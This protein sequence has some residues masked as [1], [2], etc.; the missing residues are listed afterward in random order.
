[1]PFK[2]STSKDSPSIFVDDDYDDSAKEEKFLESLRHIDFFTPVGGLGSDRSR[3]SDPKDGNGSERA[4]KKARQ[5]IQSSKEKA[6]T[7]WQVFEAVYGADLELDG[8]A[9]IVHFEDEATT[10]S[11]LMAK[12]EKALQMSSPQATKGFYERHLDMLLENRKF[13][14]V[15]RYLERV[16]KQFTNRIADD[17]GEMRHYEGGFGR[18]QI[19][20]LPEWDNLGEILFGTKDA[21]TQE[22]ITTWLCGA[23][24]RALTPGCP[25]KRALIIKGD[26]DAG[27]SAFTRILAKSWGTELRAGTTEADIIRLCKLTWIMELSECDRLFKGKEASVIKSLLSTTKDTYIQKYKEADEASVTE[28]VTLFIGTTNESQ[29]LVD[30]TG[31]KR[32][33]VID[34]A[35][36]WKLP[37][38]WLEANVDQLW[39]T[40]YHKLMFEGHQTDLS[41]SSLAASEVRNSNYMVEG[42]WNE[43]LEG[44]L[45]TITKGGAKEVAFKIADIQT[46]MGTHV[47]NQ[48]KNKAAVIKSLQQLGYEQRPI[49]VSGKTERIYALKTAKKPRAVKLG[50]NGWLYSTSSG[51]WLLDHEVGI[52]DRKAARGQA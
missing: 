40:A 30:S 17:D 19:Q 27:K 43:Q 38:D 16:Y 22:M 41:E 25:M 34:L 13:Q 9:N 1:M 18:P 6:Y 42:S 11:R 36:G 45:A 15:K 44:T 31:N 24:K 8:W 47:D 52:E 21:L 37:L 5:F 23:V 20:P 39:A 26:Q 7:F 10:R 12:L 49:K 33:W 35:D 46:A 51:E 3:W 32:F 2:N 50:V 29:F 48:G 4:R 28:R 14:P